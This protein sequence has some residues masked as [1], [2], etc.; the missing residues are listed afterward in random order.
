MIRLLSKIWNDKRGNAL[1]I[2][3]AS[4]PLLVGAAGLATDTIQWVTWKRELQRA[5]DSAAFAGVYALAQSNPAS[6]AVATDL[7]K[8]NHTLVALKTGF[9]NCSGKCK[10][11]FPAS[12]DWENG[13][14]VTL[15]VQ[16]TLGFSSLFLSTAPT[17]TVSGTA[18]MLDSGDYCVVALGKGSGAGIT[19]GGS[20]NTNM[21]CDGIS[22][23]KGAGSVVQNGGASSFT[24][25][26]MAAAGTM[27]SSI[28][29]VTTLK[30]NHL[31][32]PDPYA[33]KFSTSVPSGMSCTNFN[34][35]RTNLGTGQNPNYH[36]SPG[37]Y[38]A[39]APNGN[40]TYTLDPGVYFIDS[41]NF[42]LNGQDTLIGSNVT[43]ILTGTTP[44]SVSINGTSTLKLSAPTA[45]NCGVFGGVNTC[46]YE[47]M[48]FIQSSAASLNNNN[49]INGTNG[50]F[51]DG[52]FYFP[53]GA[54][55]M[56]GNAGSLTNCAMLVANQVVFTG[57]SN[58]QNTLTHPDGTACKANTTVAGKE[59]RLIG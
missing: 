25:D 49:T 10:I 48:L 22:N 44:G 53:S 56:S 47:D 59:V 30:P 4:L 54:L 52:A 58:L 40:N 31:P 19:I 35:H 17:I 3:G 41:A 29:G 18:A 50:S 9:P 38:S 2:A 45:T 32:L 33:G 36:L 1:I 13:V 23:K 51:L 8:N 39:F 43:I 12:S 46:N 15:A 24:A 20:S 34:T 42:T 16:R 11:E 55:N 57:N 26:I 28:T 27:P 37:C 14:K 21:G 7:T 6:S 5:A